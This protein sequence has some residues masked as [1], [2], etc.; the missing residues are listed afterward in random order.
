[1]LEKRP[2]LNRDVATGRVMGAWDTVRGL[3]RVGAGDW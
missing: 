3:G 2:S 1:M